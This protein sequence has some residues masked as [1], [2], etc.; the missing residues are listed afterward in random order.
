MGNAADRWLS[1][2]RND[3]CNRRVLRPCDP[4]LYSSTELEQQGIAL[5]VTSLR[6]LKRAHMANEQQ[7]ATSACWGLGVGERRL[8]V[9]VPSVTT[10][11]GESDKRESSVS[12]SN[13]GTPLAS[14]GCKMAAVPSSLFSKKKLQ[15]LRYDRQTS[16]KGHAP[17]RKLHASQQMLQKKKKKLWIFYGKW[18]WKDYLTRSLSLCTAE[19]WNGSSYCTGDSWAVWG[20]S[21]YRAQT[22]ARESPICLIFL[23]VLLLFFHNF[24]IFVCKDGGCLN[25][26]LFFKPSFWNERLIF[27]VADSIYI[28]KTKYFRPE[29]AR[30]AAFVKTE[31]RS[32]ISNNE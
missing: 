24:H 20:A 12:G 30:G 7:K 8:T 4:L 10:S 26:I 28:T 2:P 21:L 3:P 17:K 31:L 14:L 23:L 25:Y 22:K 19:C 9:P 15:S 18:K 27:L 32:F 29:I 1:D 6:C 5:Q 13:D 11:S 16:T